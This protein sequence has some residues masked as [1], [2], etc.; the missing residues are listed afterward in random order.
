MLT[1]QPGKQELEYFLGVKLFGAHLPFFSIGRTLGEGEFQ[2]VVFVFQ[3]G[4]ASEGWVGGRALVDHLL[5]AVVAQV[6]LGLQQVRVH[7]IAL[8]GV[9]EVLWLDI[10][11]VLIRSTSDR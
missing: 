1:T 9:G 3:L 7:R 4:L 2:P 5:R 8:V 10:V 11:V 6:Q